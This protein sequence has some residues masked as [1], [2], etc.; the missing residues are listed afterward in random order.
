MPVF[1]RYWIPSD[2]DDLEHPN[3]FRLKTLSDAQN[4][5]LK[6]IKENFPLPGK[7]HFRFR[8][9]IGDIS[10]WQDISDENAIVPLFEGTIFSKV[11]RLSSPVFTIAP[12]QNNVSEQNLNDSSFTETKKTFQSNTIPEITQQKEEQLLQMD[13]PTFS[14][15][16]VPQDFFTTSNDLLNMGSDVVSSPQLSPHNLS[17]PLQGTSNS[18]SPVPPNRYNY[19]NSSQQQQ[20]R[21]P[22]SALSQPVLT[23][24]QSYTTPQYQQSQFSP[25]PS[26][27]NMQQQNQGQQVFRNNA[28]QQQTKDNRR[29]T[30]FS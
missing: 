3:V 25:F 9:R 12:S 15:K 8:R 27:F 30:T 19:S 16:K 5:Q 24:M 21:D 23:P 13:S 4:V 26:N 20:S 11:E 1:V 7:Y 28:Q 22:F 14:T 17:I 18:T 6:D 2:G 10:V 29:N